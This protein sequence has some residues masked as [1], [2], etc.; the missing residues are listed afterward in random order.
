MGGVLPTTYDL[1]N[2]I[3]RIKIRIGYGCNALCDGIK[4]NILKII[5][6]LNL[7]PFKN[8]IKIK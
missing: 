4:K 1:S 2:I 3:K 7:F 6:S 5:V 8:Y